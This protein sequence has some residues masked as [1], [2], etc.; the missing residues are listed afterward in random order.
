VPIASYD[1][2]FGKKGGAAKALRAMVKEYGAEKGQR[3][4]YAMVNKRKRRGS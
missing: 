1:R 4:F 2:Y 3:V